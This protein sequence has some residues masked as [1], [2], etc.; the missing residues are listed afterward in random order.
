MEELKQEQVEYLVNN[1]G[2]LLWLFIPM[3]GVS[4]F[5]RVINVVLSR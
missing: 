3:L 4:L 5:K 2:M 1:W